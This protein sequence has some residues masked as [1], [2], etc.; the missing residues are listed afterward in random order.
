M[1]PL[2]ADGLTW[3]SLDN[4]FNCTSSYSD[5]VLKKLNWNPSL[6]LRMFCLD[7][8]DIILAI[9]F[10]MQCF[11]LLVINSFYQIHICFGY[12]QNHRNRYKE[13][14]F[15]SWISIII[16]IMHHKFNS[17]WI[18]ITSFESSRM[19][20]SP[21]LCWSWNVKFLCSSLHQSPL[22]QHHSM[23]IIFITKVLPFH[24][25][26]S[27]CWHHIISRCNAEV[28]QMTTPQPVVFKY[29]KL[30]VVLLKTCK[31]GSQDLPWDY[32]M[33]YSWWI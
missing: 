7:K 18:L 3:I 5:K 1:A 17:I 13:S 31:Y 4:C 19:Q 25:Y 21:Y 24:L 26:H 2:R 20:T 28:T 15:Q 14:I 29:L 22:K 32:N 23:G 12:V 10:Q 6:S 11:H 30:Y 33:A 27:C 9:P 16:I 8:G